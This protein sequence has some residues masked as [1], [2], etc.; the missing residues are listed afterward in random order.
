MLPMTTDVSR[1]TAVCAIGGDDEP[2]VDGFV[3]NARA[4]ASVVL[5]GDT[6]STDGTVRRLRAGRVT[7]IDVPRAVLLGGGFAAA[8]NYVL[9]RVPATAAWIHWLDLDERITIDGDPLPARQPY[10]DVTTRTYAFDSRVDLAGWR[11]LIDRPS[12]EEG[13]TR[14]HRNQPQVRWAG[15]VHE[16]LWGSWHRRERVGVIHHHL[17]HFRD[18]ARQ[19]R[20]RGLY[21]FLLWRGLSDRALRRGTN[22]WWF[23]E[24]IRHLSTDALAAERDEARRFFDENRADISF[25][26]DWR[27][28]SPA[29]WQR[30]PWSRR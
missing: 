27:L 18:A 2:F 17:T 9:D 1:Q 23:T 11:N 16:E 19:A 28:P 13:H 25:D 5:V 26:V 30:L 15:L 4:R 29:W 14:I 12:S 7:V 6:G 8:R 24:R 21:T 20:R 3:E 22:P 10:G